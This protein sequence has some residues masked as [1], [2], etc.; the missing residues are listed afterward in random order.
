MPTWSHSAITVRRKQPGYRSEV[1]K[2]V[3]DPE[4]ERHDDHR[5]DSHLKRCPPG[6][7]AVGRQPLQEPS[8][9]LQVVGRALRISLESAAGFGPRRRGHE[10]TDR[11]PAARVRVVPAGG[12]SD[13]SA[14]GVRTHG[15]YHGTGCRRRLALNQIQPPVKRPTRAQVLRRPLGRSHPAPRSRS[16]AVTSRTPPWHGF[17]RRS[18][19]THRIGGEARRSRCRLAE[20]IGPS[21]DGGACPRTRPV[22]G[23]LSGRRATSW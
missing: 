21:T 23:V 7:S 4:R 22:P 18:Q 12:P 19:G 8:L 9:T 17:T 15:H 5:G 10:M 14:R 1:M 20:W 3:R 6:T 16:G 2:R 11:L 13:A